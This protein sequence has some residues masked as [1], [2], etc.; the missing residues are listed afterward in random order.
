MRPI[1]IFDTNIFGDVQ[2]GDIPAGDWRYLLRHR[3]G[4][5]WPLSLVTALELHMFQSALLR[6]FMYRN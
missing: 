3:P 5:G 1:P 4:H 2:S 6:R